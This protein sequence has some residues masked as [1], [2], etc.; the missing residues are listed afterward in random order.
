MSGS[1]IPAE[2]RRL[3]PTRAF[4]RCEYCLAPEIFSFQPH[5]VDHI[6]AQKHDGKTV[7]T[8]LAL[9]CVPCN[10]FK[11]SDLTSIDPATGAIAALFHPRRDKWTQHFELQG[12]LM[13]PKSPTG[14][15][16]VKLLQFNAPDRV[17][18]RALFAHV[19][20]LV[21]PE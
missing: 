5:Q 2:L 16:T 4:G 7:E 15:V 18:E 20:E 3:V 19:N 9:C 10:L 17:A 6:V 8:N 13:I 12:L 1:H 21:V 14:R 11:G